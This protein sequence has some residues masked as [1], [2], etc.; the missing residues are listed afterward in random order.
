MFKVT[1]EIVR[2]Q[3]RSVRRHYGSSVEARY[4]ASPDKGLHPGEAGDPT[5][6]SSSALLYTTIARKLLL[7]M[8]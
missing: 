7:A 2:Q 4:A 6:T 3:G 8:A 1:T 5:A